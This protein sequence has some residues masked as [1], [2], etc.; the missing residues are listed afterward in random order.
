MYLVVCLPDLAP[1]LEQNGTGIIA[2]LI[3][4]QDTAA[5]LR[6]QRKNGRKLIEV[7]VQ[8]VANLICVL[9]TAVSLD[10]AS[11]FQKPADAQQFTAA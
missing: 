6:G 7:S 5:D 11:G 10:L 3:F 9:V 4:F 2:D 1:D 8:T